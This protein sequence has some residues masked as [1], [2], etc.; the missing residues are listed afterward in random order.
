M[1]TLPNPIKRLFI[2]GTVLLFISTAVILIL[3]RSILHLRKDIQFEE[4]FIASAEMVQPNFERSLNAYT[5]DTKQ[6][7]EYVLELRPESESELIH[8]INEIETIGEQLNLNIDLESLSK[9]KTPGDP[10]ATLSYELNFYGN[11]EQS[12][13]FLEALEAMTYYVRILSFEFSDPSLSDDTSILIPNVSLT[14]QLYV[15]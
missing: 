6:T 8:F 14:F 3:S 7:I 4:Q 12:I 2:V 9:E 5:D 13:A 1:P 10:S 15:R 11:Y